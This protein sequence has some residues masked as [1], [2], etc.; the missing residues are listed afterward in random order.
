MGAQMLG[1]FDIAR[2]VERAG[3]VGGAHDRA[4]HRGR[5]AGIG[6]QVAVAQIVRRE[7]RCAAGQIQDDIAARRGA[8]APGAERELRARGGRR[9]RVVVDG[10][11]EGAEMSLGGC[12]SCP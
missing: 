11:V 9:L 7:Q 3:E 2:L 6:A 10:E 4:Q 1:E 8:V 5:I 12:G